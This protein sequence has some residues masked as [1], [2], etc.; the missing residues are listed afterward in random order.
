MKRTIFLGAGHS[1]QVGSD[2]G[3]PPAYANIGFTEGIETVKFRDLIF[4]KLEVLG[5]CAVLDANE[6]TGG[7]TIRLYKT[8]VQKEDIAIDIHF[9]SYGNP[10]ISGTE[11]FVGKNASAEEKKMAAALS[12]KMAEILNINNRG[13][14]SETQS[15]RKRLG[16]FT[17]P[18]RYRLL[19]EVCFITSPK[20][21]KGF[22]D[23]ER[24][25]AQ[26]LA[27]II[28]QYAT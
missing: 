26:A 7:T 3:A 2:M 15:A 27:E 28:H 12:L 14:K 11:V 18:C 13:V 17:L 4:Q 25:L 20:D 19:I 9:N 1:N 24:L 22:K 8:K 6:N 21:M 10:S 5:H 16:W 23:N